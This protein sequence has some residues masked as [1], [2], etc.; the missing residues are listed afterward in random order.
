MLCASS[1]PLPDA[2]LA[3]SILSSVV[4]ENGGRVIPF[5]SSVGQ[6]VLVPQG[7]VHY[8]LNDNC[9]PSKFISVFNNKDPGV[10]TAYQ[11]L[12]RLSPDVLL[13]TTG[14]TQAALNAAAPKAQAVFV[15]SPPCLARC[16]LAASTG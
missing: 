1:Q 7:L 2:P 12:L 3:G 8:T 6:S 10:L 14:Q 11:N 5:N 15:L 9:T 4:E 16:G 13:A